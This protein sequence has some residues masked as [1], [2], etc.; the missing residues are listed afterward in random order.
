MTRYITVSNPKASQ[1]KPAV[2]IV[3]ETGEHIVLSVKVLGPSWIGYTDSS[4]IAVVTDSEIE[5]V[6]GDSDNR[7][8]N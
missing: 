6:D 4:R 8:P 1:N 2:R 7:S 5:V 3:D